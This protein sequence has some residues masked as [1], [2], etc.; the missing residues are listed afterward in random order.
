MP[1][2]CQPTE[3]GRLWSGLVLWTLSPGPFSALSPQLGSLV[4][5]QFQCWLVNLTLVN[6]FYRR[7]LPMMQN[8]GG[9]PTGFFHSTHISSSQGPRT[10]DFSQ[11]LTH[12]LT[13][14]RCQ[15]F[16]SQSRLR[17]L[18]T[19]WNRVWKGGGGKKG[20]EGWRDDTLSSE[21]PAREAWHPGST[22]DTLSAEGL[23]QRWKTGSSQARSEPLKQKT[24][25][26]HLKI[27]FH[28][29]IQI[30]GFLGKN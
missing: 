2:A 29:Q 6:A 3:R 4:W 21:I 26:Q 1:L 7:A 30:A 28:V 8:S 15:L 20:A 13:S 23:N 5:I 9:L 22:K 16:S 25:C 10:S 24:S 19:S 17:A 27:R 18:D 14:C 12:F 11:R